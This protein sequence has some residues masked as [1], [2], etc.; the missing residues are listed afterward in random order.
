VVGHVYATFVKLVLWGVPSTILVTGIVVWRDWHALARGGIEGTGLVQACMWE[1]AGGIKTKTRAGYF[2]CD[3]TYRTSADGPVYEGH[4]Q[5]QQ[6]RRAGDTVPIRFLRGRPE[7]SAAAET[8]QH[9]SITAGGMI[10][11]AVAL[12]AWIARGRR[13]TQG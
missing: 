3:Y 11:G 5:S 6:Q 13:R 1:R 2:S 7:T 12:L 4:F 8:L 9:P 10:A